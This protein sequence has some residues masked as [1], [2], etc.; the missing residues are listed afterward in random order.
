MTQGSPSSLSTSRRGSD[1]QELI[2]CD[3]SRLDRGFQLIEVRD[4]NLSAQL[5]PGRPALARE[6]RPV[7]VSGRDRQP[8]V[9]LHDELVVLTRRQWLPDIG[10]AQ[11]RPTIEHGEDLGPPAPRPVREGEARDHLVDDAR[12]RR[13]NPRC[14]SS[15]RRGGCGASPRRSGVD[16]RIIG[17]RLPWRARPRVRGHAPVGPMPRP[18]RTDRSSSSSV[19]WP[20]QL[21]T[22]RVAQPERPIRIA[23]AH[24][25]APLGEAGARRSW[26]SRRGSAGPT[27]STIRGSAS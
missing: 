10:Q 21:P 14:R 27:W 18:S 8:L 4:A 12:R 20:R 17:A 7:V 9:R 19:V 13:P 1:V 11:R 26:A 25:H 24:H 22:I 6:D 2:P 15:A 3:A 5:P 23:D 16:H